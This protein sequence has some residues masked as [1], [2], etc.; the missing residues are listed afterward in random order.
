MRSIAAYDQY[1]TDLAIWKAQYGDA[2]P[3]T[4]LVIRPWP[5]KAPVPPRRSNRP[6]GR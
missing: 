6:P 5:A 1:R 2:Q 3:G 4:R